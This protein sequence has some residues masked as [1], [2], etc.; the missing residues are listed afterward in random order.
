MQAD[1]THQW[2]LDRLSAYIDGGLDAGEALDVAA[3]LAS[4]E[5]CAGEYTHR[6]STVESMQQTSRPSAHRTHCASPRGR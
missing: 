1:Q 2:Y 3:H 6:L 5:S 4:C